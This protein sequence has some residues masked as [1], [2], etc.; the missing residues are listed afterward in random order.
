[1]KA[2]IDAVTG[3]LEIYAL[4][5]P[6]PILRTYR[7][8]FPTLVREWDEM[9]ERVRAHLRYPNL[10]FRVQAEVLEQYHLERPEAFYA[11]QDVW[12]LPQDVSAQVRRRG[13]PN[14]AIMPL[15]GETQPEFLL[16]SAFIA[17]ER[18][19]MTAILLARSDMPNYGRLMLLEMPRDEQI[20]GPS[21]LQA[22]IEQD[23]FISQQLALWRQA[24]RTVEMG[25]LR[26]IPT[27]GSIL[28]VQPLFLSAQDRG[29]PQLQRVIV[30]D[31]SSVAMA[32][33]FRGAIT[34]LGGE[35]LDR[36]QPRPADAPDGAAAPPATAADEAWR[37][38]ALELMREADNRIRTGDFAGFGAAWNRLRTH[39]EQRPQNRNPQ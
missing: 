2:T 13:R 17:R 31:G 36:P 35:L 1:V 10:K 32:E 34:A 38:Q 33:D 4:P 7:R 29:I 18:Q 5:D 37:Q 19:N 12:Q 24:G 21:Q 28:Y 27:G 30:S 39:L 25:R 15:P 16:S 23:P 3:Q 14:Y 20:R 6:D 8:V 9:P 11:G 22:L 26:I